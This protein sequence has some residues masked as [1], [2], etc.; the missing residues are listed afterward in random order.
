[1]RIRRHINTPKK[2]PPRRLKKLPAK[3][4]YPVSALAG[5]TLGLC[6]L[7]TG[8]LLIIR[9]YQADPEI[10]GISS[11]G[12]GSTA[13]ISAGL[14]GGPI[15]IDAGLLAVSGKTNTPVRVI[16][17]S[18]RIDLPIVPAPVVNGVWKTSAVSASHGL[19]SAN[20]G[21]NGN[22][23]IFAHARERL[24][25][26]LRD[27]KENDPVYLLTADGWYRYRVESFKLVNPEDV[28]VI[29]ATKE[30]VL[31]LFT[32]TGFLDS[33]RLIVKALPDN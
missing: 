9:S 3:K 27:V 2:F 4:R 12:T 10:T 22:T 25:L 14:A 8:I 33:K 31:T 18:V 30:E 20:P 5:Y 6:L 7:I 29:A 11:N 24:F 15:R 21:E 28:E 1:M 32:C 26:P 23:V 16:I 13:S 19:G 17:P